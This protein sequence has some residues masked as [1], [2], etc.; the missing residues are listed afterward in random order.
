MRLS[1]VLLLILITAGLAMGQSRP[2]D[3]SR[4]SITVLVSRAGVF[5]FIADNHTIQAPIAVG[6]VD[7]SRQSVVLEIEAR[8][9]KVLDPNLS[10]DKR[11]E[12]QQ[13]MLGPDVL[14]VDRYPRVVFHSS[15]AS[16]NGQQIVLRGTLDLHGHQEPLELHAVAAEGG[17]RGS[18]AI[19]QTRFGI[20]P[21][22]FAGGAVRVK[23]EVRIQFVI[24]PETAGHAEV[25]AI[26][27]SSQNQRRR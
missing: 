1:S 17:Y 13:R 3:A 20:Q 5:S 25:P 16:R 15:S 8:Q 12:V 27:G 19:R 21:V 7:E 14:N 2:I 9:M 23:D 22:K 24:F 18:V 11:A 26:G 4:S 10:P 6:T